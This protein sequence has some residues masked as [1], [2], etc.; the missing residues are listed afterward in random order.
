ME[1]YL[2]GLDSLLAHGADPEAKIPLGEEEALG[3]P[4]SAR[5]WF[6]NELQQPLGRGLNK[7]IIGQ[8]ALR[9]LR[10]VEDEGEAD[11]AWKI[12]ES[13]LPH[14]IYERIRIA[15]AGSKRKRDEEQ[16]QLGEV[17]KRSIRRHLDL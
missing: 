1:T 5:E 2:L 7:R 3:S 9:L 17:P 4:I 14:V 8:V 16:E 13:A 12:L 10:R 6:F 11:A 15:M